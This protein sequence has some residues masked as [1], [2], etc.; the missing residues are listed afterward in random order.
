MCGAWRKKIIIEIKNSSFEELYNTL[1][2]EFPLLSNVG[3]IE[4]MRTGFASKSK[5]LEVIPTPHGST[6]YSIEY[7]KEVLQQAKC[8]VRPIQRDIPMVMQDTCTLSV[9]TASVQVRFHHFDVLF[10]L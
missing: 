1:L 10:T 6:T 9:D 3:G 8:Y 7:L 2:E 4:L 5:T